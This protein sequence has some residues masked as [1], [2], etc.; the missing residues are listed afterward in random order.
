MT[1]PMPMLAVVGDDLP[2]TPA[3]DTLSRATEALATAQAE[4]TEAAKP[5]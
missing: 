4:Q 1:E 3:H 2:L 5:A